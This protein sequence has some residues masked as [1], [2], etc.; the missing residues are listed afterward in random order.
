MHAT[1]PKGNN[2]GIWSIHCSWHCSCRKYFC[3]F[4]LAL[5]NIRPWPLV[6]FSQ[7][8]LKN[9]N[10]VLP[11]IPFGIVACTFSDNLSR[12]SYIMKTKM[13]T[14]QSIHHTATLWSFLMHSLY[15]IFVLSGSA[16]R[17]KRCWRHF[18]SKDL[19]ERNCSTGWWCRVYNDRETSFNCICR[20]S[21]S[22]SIILQLS[23]RGDWCLFV[24]LLLLCNLG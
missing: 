14:N 2:Y 4:P 20:T 5:T 22:Y 23:N 24:S 3:C 16:S 13:V 10:S 17:K 18:C 21:L 9:M 6:P 15:I 7:I 1:I 11:T 12:N 8:S 19:E